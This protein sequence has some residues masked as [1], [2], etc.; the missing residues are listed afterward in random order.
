[1]SKS[2][3]SQT[4]RWQFIRKML[5]MM[6][7][8]ALISGTFQYFILREQI[9]ENVMNEALMIGNSIEHGIKETD[10]ASKSIEQQIDYKLESISARIADH[11]QGKSLDHITDQDLIRLRDQFQIAGITLFARKG[12]DIVGVKSSDP[13]EIGFSFKSIMQEAFLALDHLLQGKKPEGNG[14]VSY[15]NQN[16]INLYIAQSG[17]HDDKPRFFKYAYY[18]Q[19]GTDYVINPYI[20]ANEVYQFTQEVGPDS[21]IKK[22]LSENKYAKE[23]AVLDPRVFEDPSLAEKMYP[24]LKKIVYGTYNDQTQEDEQ[25]L[26]QMDKS[27]QRVSYVQKFNSEKLY[28]MFIPFDEG[29]VIYISLDYETMS[30]PLYRQSLILIIFGLLSL[31]ALFILTA[32]F[33]NSIYRNIQKIIIQI[34][35][36]EAGDLTAKSQ[37]LDGGELGELSDSTNTMVDT[38]H[39][40]LTDTREKATQAQKLSVLLETDANESLEKA[41]TMSMEATAESRDTVEEIYYFLDQLEK[42]LVQQLDDPGAKVIMDKLDEMRQLANHRTNNTTEITIALSDLF[43]ALHEQSS[44]LSDLSHSLLDD[45]AKF[46]LQ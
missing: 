10:L 22:V 26:V 38:L 6:I 19:P 5:I 8:I 7:T 31:V 11:L 9:N 46:K 16:I 20:E 39:Q 43:K 3:A 32:N 36:L 45:L 42:H 24:P 30:A 18:H 29:R 17:S 13:K 21:W 44:E 4:L 41:F 23:I 37:I 33:F 28:K 14:I 12:D 1:M 34:K 2:T 35:Q 27:A 15:V 25:I 40:L